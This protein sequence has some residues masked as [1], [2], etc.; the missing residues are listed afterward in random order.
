MVEIKGFLQ[1]M[2][3]EELRGIDLHR[4]L[5]EAVRDAVHGYLG[6]VAGAGVMETV[7]APEGVAATSGGAI[8]A[9]RANGPDEGPNDRP[10]PAGP[11]GR[12]VYG[13][14]EGDGPDRLGPIGIG[15]A[16]VYR[17]AEGNLSAVVHDCPPEP[18]RSEDEGQVE[19]WLFTHEE[20]LDRVREIFGIAVPA[21]FNT[22]LYRAGEDPRETV[23]KWL[24]QEGDRLRSAVEKLRGREEYAVQVFVDEEVLKEAVAADPGIRRMGEEISGSPE[25]ARYLLEQNLQR[26]VGQALEEAAEA[27]FREVFEAVRGA[28]RDLRV[29]KTGRPDGKRRMIANL[30]CLCDA[31]RRQ[32]LDRALG[33]IERRPGYSVRY[34]GPWAPYSFVG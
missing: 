18:Y 34:T 16:E 9:H 6:A 30:S 27:A 15:G 26:A 21:S 20:V 8:P 22:I 23:R 25:G 14:T 10:A 12:Y 29:E 33:E 17:I 11:A 13:V 32:E 19:A 31:G 4:I 24:L 3:E 5:R 7:P 1:R 2:V 28:V